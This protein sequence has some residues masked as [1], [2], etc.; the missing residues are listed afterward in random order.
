MLV[1]AY[2][3]LRMRNAKYEYFMLQSNL[4]T[5]NSEFATI[6]RILLTEVLYYAKLDSSRRLAYLAQAAFRITLQVQLRMRTRMK[7][8]PLQ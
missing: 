1:Q 7:Y 6:N 8:Q 2:E 5:R 4:S 3:I